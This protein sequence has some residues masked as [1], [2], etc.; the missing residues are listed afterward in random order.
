ME[1]TLTASVRA[2]LAG[3][4]D[5]GKEEFLGIMLNRPYWFDEF[6]FSSIQCNEIKQVDP[7]EAPRDNDRR[8]MFRRQIFIVTKHGGK[9]LAR[10]TVSCLSKDNSVEDKEWKLEEL[11]YRYSSQG[12]EYAII[13]FA[14]RQITVG[15]NADIF[16]TL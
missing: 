13:N 6:D 8:K 1:I 9:S 11:V 3:L 2:A 15:C 12:P 16:Y 14:G 5:L 4:A 10:I 7:A